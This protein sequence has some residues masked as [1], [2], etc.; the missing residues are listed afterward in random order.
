MA[1]EVKEKGGNYGVGKSAEVVIQI[2]VFVA[3]AFWWVYSWLG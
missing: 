1:Y 2:A 3:L